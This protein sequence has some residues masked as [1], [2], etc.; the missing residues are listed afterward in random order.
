MNENKCTFCG[1]LLGNH[2]ALVLHEKY[3]CINNPN[4]LKRKGGNDFTKARRLGLPDPQHLSEEGRSRLAEASKRRGQSEKTKE[5]LSK[6]AKSAGF[7]GHESKQHL[8]YKGVCLHS[9]YETTL[10]IDLDKNNIKWFRPN[11]MGWIDDEGKNHRYYADFY[12]P[13]Y[14]IYLDPK[15]DFLIEHVNPVFGITDREK[16]NKVAEQNNV[17]IFILNK[18]QLLWNYVQTLL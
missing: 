16:I 2:G 12:L 15:N 4:R 17:R 13:D 9:S 6:I 10:A 14:D 18:D 11:P 7:G 3:Y 8:I 1:R 5:K